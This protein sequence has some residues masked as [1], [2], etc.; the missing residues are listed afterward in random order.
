MLETEI[1]TEP[2]KVQISIGTPAYNRANLALFCAGFVTFI[3]LY[4]L[5]PLL[6]LFAKE[7]SVSPAVASLPLSVPRWLWRWAC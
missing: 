6:P 2:R 1:C 5:Q 4:D 3:T 7:F